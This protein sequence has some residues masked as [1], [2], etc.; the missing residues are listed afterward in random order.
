MIKTL[1]KTEQ[2]ALR[3]GV[4][5]DVRHSTPLLCKQ[6]LSQC[7]NTINSDGLK[8]T[9]PTL[10]CEWENAICSLIFNEEPNN[11]GKIHSKQF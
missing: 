9:L 6:S 1:V 8:G 11:S 2:S 7:Q 10:K 4:L 5:P 3:E